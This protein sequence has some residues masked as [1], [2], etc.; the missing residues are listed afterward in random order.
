M[1]SLYHAPSGSRY[2]ILSLPS[3]PL[4]QS[5]GVFQGAI[6]TK[7]STYKLGGPVLLD[8]QSREIAIGKDLALQVAVEWLGGVAK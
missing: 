1:A 7:R 3:S 4:L 6:I 2:R 5:L 8:I